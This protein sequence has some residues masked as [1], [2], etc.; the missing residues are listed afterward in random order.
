MNSELEKYR[1]PS[2]HTNAAYKIPFGG[3]F[4]FLKLYGT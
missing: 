4:V 2:V 1:I 3:D